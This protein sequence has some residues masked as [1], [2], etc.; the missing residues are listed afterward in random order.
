MK[1]RPL[2]PLIAIAVFGGVP[3]AVAVTADPFGPVEV[4][5]SVYR[6][7]TNYRGD[8]P[9]VGSDGSGNVLLGTIFKDHGDAYVQ[10]CKMK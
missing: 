2:L 6:P 9:F 5:D 3:A 4:A 8:P 1:L 10:D 7:A